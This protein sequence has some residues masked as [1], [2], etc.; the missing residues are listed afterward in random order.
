MEL[1]ETD[2]VNGLFIETDV[3]TALPTEY[4]YHLKDHLGNVRTT[5]TTKDEQDVSLATMETANQTAERGK[6]LYYDNARRINSLLFDHTRSGATNYSVR[7][8]GSANEKVG[9]TKS[10]SVMP[11]DKIQIEVFAKYVDPVNTNWTTALATLLT[12]IATG[13]APAGTVIDG[14]GYATNSTTTIP[15]SGLLAKA[16]GTNAAPMAYVNF[17]SFDR[18]F[19]PQTDDTQTNFVRITEAPKKTAATAPTKDCMWK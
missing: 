1:Y 13:T 7:L 2:P 16:P 4:Q 10:L 5:F 6:F 18:N 17:I 19:L 12:A 11:G 9:L 3:P 8:N 14:A 15:G